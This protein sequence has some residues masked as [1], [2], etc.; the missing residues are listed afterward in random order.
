MRLGLGFW[1]GRRGAPPEVAITACD[2]VLF[3]NGVTVISGTGS[4]G[5]VVSVTIGGSA[6]GAT[7]VAGG[8]WSIS[9]RV[10][11]SIAGDSVTVVAQV[12][13][14][15]DAVSRT[16]LPCT[17]RL[18]ATKGTTIE[19]GVSLWSD[20]VGSYHVSQGSTAE[21]PALAAKTIEFDGANKHLVRTDVS[22]WG[23]SVAAI[24]AAV[25]FRCDN[26]ATSQGIF[27]TGPFD[28]VASSGEFEALLSGNQLYVRA[29][30]T[31]N[32]IIVPFTSTAMTVL[33]ITISGGTMT[34]YVSG[35]SIGTAGSVAN[36]NFTGLN[37]YTGIYRGL[38]YALLGGLGDVAIGIGSTLSAPQ[39]AA[40][41][42]Y[43]AV[44]NG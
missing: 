28:G 13:G 39:I 30:N 6:F 10:P 17:V 33:I 35:S 40:L 1:G 29:N 16:V 9:A 37:F 12:G 26:A 43:L 15:T 14:S 23:S 7:T 24:W 3:E 25:A 41:N 19:T 20:Q 42:S 11:T 5:W 34:A 4:E 44:K 22:A 21:Q 8:T 18:D 38:S 2:S 36:L 32:A 27:Q 31:A